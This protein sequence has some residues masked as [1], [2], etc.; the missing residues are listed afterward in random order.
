MSTIIINLTEFVNTNI[1]PK[2]DVLARARSCTRSDVLRDIF[3]SSFNYSPLQRSQEQI[4]AD[5]EIEMSIE[6][7]CGKDKCIAAIIESQFQDVLMHYWVAR[8]GTYKQSINH[9]LSN[10]FEEYPEGWSYKITDA[11]DAEL[12]ASCTASVTE[13]CSDGKN[14][15]KGRVIVRKPEQVK[16]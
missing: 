11:K 16:A 2:I 5:C 14:P 1:L 13:P 4:E 3:Y 10:Y 9:I 15:A 6:R 8:H 12:R 7:K